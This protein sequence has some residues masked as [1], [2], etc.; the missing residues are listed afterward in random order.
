MK[1]AWKLKS[2]MGYSSFSEALKHAWLVAKNEVKEREIEAK[3]EAIRA[4]WKAEAD[5][6]RKAV[7]DAEKAKITASGLD[8]HA[9]T[10][11]NY[12]A[13]HTYNGD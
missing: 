8:L 1:Q 6:K 13:R 3:N 4:H 12:Y 11:S 2:M 7:A 10:M 9:Y 5:A